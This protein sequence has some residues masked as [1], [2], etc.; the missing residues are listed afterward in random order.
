MVIGAM[1]DGLKQMGQGMQAMGQGL[2][3]LHFKIEMV[4]EI[5]MDKGTVTREELEGHYKQVVQDKINEIV[6]LD[7]KKG[8]DMLIEYKLLPLVPLTKTISDILIQRRQLVRA[9]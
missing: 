6:R 3:M 5:L 7:D 9:L 8:I 2:D 1:D 4:L